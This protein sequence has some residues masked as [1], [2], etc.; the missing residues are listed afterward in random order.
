MTGV[1]SQA[2]P[3]RQ[4]QRRRQPF[5]G[6]MDRSNRYIGTAAIAV[7]VRTIPAIPIIIPRT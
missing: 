1:P 6:Q 3:D 5:E 7:A 2:P 4:N